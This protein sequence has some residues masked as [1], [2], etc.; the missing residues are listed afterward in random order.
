MPR[1]GLASGENGRCGSDPLPHFGVAVLRNVGLVA[2]VV[3]TVFL[4]GAS[5]LT[6]L[7]GGLLI[8][9]AIGA[10]FGLITYWAT[11]WRHG[12]VGTTDRP[13]QRHAVEV[14]RAHAIEAVQVLDQS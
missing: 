12:F 7:L 6:L 3:V 4:A 8:G 13:A 9:A 11:D 10:V 2:G 14:D 1:G 5:W